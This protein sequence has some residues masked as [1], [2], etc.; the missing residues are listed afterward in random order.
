MKILDSLKKYNLQE[1]IFNLV[2]FLMPFGIAFERKMYSNVLFPMLVILTGIQ[3]YKNGFKISFYEKFLGVFLGSI[4]ISLIF[5]NYPIKDLSDKF[6]P[7]IKWLFFPTIFGQFNIDRKREKIVFLSVIIT[8]L[9]MYKLGLLDIIKHIKMYSGKEIGYLEIFKMENLKLMQSY[10]SGF[11]LREIFPTLTETA[12]ILGGTI[13]A[14]IMVLIDKSTDIKVKIVLIPMILM[15]LFQ[16]ILTQSRGM[17]LAFLIVIS[18][19]VM[20]KVSKRI[21]G[22]LII[23]LLGVLAI[24][25]N[26]PYVKRFESISNGDGARMEIYTSAFK[27]FKANVLTGIGFDNFIQATDYYEKASHYQ[28]PHNMALKM[29]TEMGVIG[30]LS[31]FSMMGA[32]VYKLWKTRS[33]LICE[34]MLAVIVLMLIYENFETVIVWKRASEYIFFMLGLAL[35]GNYYLLKG[36]KK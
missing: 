2:I 20:I 26:T 23:I 6:M 13:I 12:L 27:I 7:Y 30:F 29:L 18:L 21:L 33:K 1:N 11:R 17:Y 3:I 36:A 35:S 28:H 10:G 22:V 14:F 24:F 19:L 16:M 25:R 9:Y 15:G 32:I 8:T 4:V 31:Y 5:T 34:I